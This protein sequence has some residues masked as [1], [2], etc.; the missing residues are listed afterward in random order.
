MFGFFLISFFNVIF[1]LPVNYEAGIWQ[2]ALSESQKPANISFCQYSGRKSE[3]K[4]WE[5]KVKIECENESE[6]E[7]LNKFKWQM[8]AN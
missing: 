7:N 6:L 3:N 1:F 8:T 2:M 4:K 5:M